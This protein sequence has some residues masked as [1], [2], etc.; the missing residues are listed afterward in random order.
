MGVNIE[1]FRPRIG[2]F[3]SE[4]NR[5]NAVIRKGQ[6]GPSIQNSVYGISNGGDIGDW[7]SKNK[8]WLAI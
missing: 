8:P 2:G 3:V 4:S 7:W 1:T 5:G 6:K